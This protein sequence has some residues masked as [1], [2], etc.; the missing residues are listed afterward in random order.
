MFKGPLP[1]WALDAGFCVG[2]NVI[3]V[4]HP[5]K[6]RPVCL[7]TEKISSP[8]TFVVQGDVSTVTHIKKPRG[9]NGVFPRM[10]E[11]RIAIYIWE[12]HSPRRTVSSRFHPPDPPEP[13]LRSGV[14][15][16]RPP[17]SAEKLVAPAASRRPLLPA[18]G[19][20]HLPG[21]GRGRRRP[22]SQVPWRW[23]DESLNC[24]DVVVS[25]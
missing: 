9:E 7:I 4:F 22:H 21:G 3:S 14:P 15:D 12:V 24:T 20:A 5:K 18:A 10:F 6:W 11:L 25:N 17:T 2:L 16:R 13:V 8:E 19:A 1:W 23:R